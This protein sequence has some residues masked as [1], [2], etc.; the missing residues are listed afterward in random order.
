[1]LLLHGSFGS[2]R[3]WQPF[4]ELL[5]DEIYAIAPDLRGCGQSTQ[6]SEPDS[7]EISQQALDL[8][9][10]IDAL[11]WREVDLVGHSSGGAIAAELA[12]VRS[13]LLS[14]L[15]L[16]DSVPIEGVFTP[17]ETLALL[18]QMQSDR[19]LLAQCLA[20]LMP[21]YMAQRQMNSDP[22]FVQ[23]VDDASRMAPILFTA[24]A[25]ALGRWNR[26][27]DAGRLTLPTLLIWG[28]LDEIVS[29][30]AVTRTLIALPGAN[31]LEV[32]RGVG[33]SPMIEAPLTLAERIIE[34]ITED[35]SY[36]ESV[37]QV[38]G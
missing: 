34:F 4:M 14:T 13:E 6:Q 33:H 31:N 32:L 29:K 37:R 28:E 5:P 7:Y 3:W 36:F 38:E 23:L 11:G 1:M 12:L 8:A 24:L 35:F 22:F 10:F 16:V 2:S 17:L 26:F 19:G 21:T 18:Q 9:S 27:A 15:T 30:D 25:E 20:L